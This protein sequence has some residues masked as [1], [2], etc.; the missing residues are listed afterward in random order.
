M[1]RSIAASM[2]SYLFETMESFISVLRAWGGGPSNMELRR[3][4]RFILGYGG[5][6]P[7]TARRRAGDRL[8]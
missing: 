2:F 5:A 7:S 8:K 3:S 1:L 6:I 4:S